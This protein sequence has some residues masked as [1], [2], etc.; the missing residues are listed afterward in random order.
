MQATGSLGGP[1]LRSSSPML[2]TFVWQ[3][4]TSSLKRKE[5]ALRLTCGGKR[6]P[7]GMR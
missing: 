4:C 2:D 7:I 1:H 6:K 3:Y 5:K